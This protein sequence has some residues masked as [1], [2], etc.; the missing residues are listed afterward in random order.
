MFG[1]G[2]PELIVI[3]VIALVVIGPHKLPELARSLG[4][5]LAEFKRATEDFKQSVQ[6]ESRVTDEKEKLVR[7]EEG[8]EA[9]EKT[10]AATKKV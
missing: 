1:I 2:M 6:E 4:R 10:E 8:T 5:G 3:F 7:T 9:Q